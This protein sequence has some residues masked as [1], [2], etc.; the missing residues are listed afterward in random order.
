MLFKPMACPIM[1]AD[2]TTSETIKIVTNADLSTL[3]TFSN[4]GSLIM[5]NLGG[6][7][8][9][10]GERRCWTSVFPHT[11]QRCMVPPLQVDAYIKLSESLGHDPVVLKA[12][13]QLNNAMTN[14]PA[15]EPTPARL[16]YKG[17]S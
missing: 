8:P 12:V 16:Q 3:I 7:P 4:E 6:A 10:S 5:K 13:Q 15:G 9:L 2:T 11:A 17:A 14:N 1:P